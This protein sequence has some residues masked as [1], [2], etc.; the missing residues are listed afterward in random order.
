MKRVVY[1]TK[2]IKLVNDGYSNKIIK[3]NELL[4]EIT[5]TLTGA[6]NHV[7]KNYKVEIEE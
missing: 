2:G 3:K 5:D 6:V 1:F 7:I 4:D